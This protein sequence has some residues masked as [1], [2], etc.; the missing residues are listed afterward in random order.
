MERV[1]GRLVSWTLPLAVAAA[2]LRPS[3]RQG[4]T[5]RHDL[6]RAEN[7]SEIMSVIAQE[8][9]VSERFPKSE[10]QKTQ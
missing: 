6:V 2:L 3:V 5:N 8:M 4:P 10:M 7:L 1:A 9:S